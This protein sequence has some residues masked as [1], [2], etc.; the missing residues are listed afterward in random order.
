M[1]ADLLRMLPPLLLCLAVGALL[2]ALLLRAW[3]RRSRADQTLGDLPDAPAP[4]DDEIVLG[5]FDAVYVSTTRAT[6]RLSR[7]GSHTLGERSDA[8]LTLSRSD[9]GDAVV[10]HV[11]REGAESFALPQSL[12]RTAEGTSG[13]A[14]K[15]VGGEGILA[16]AWD[17]RGTDVV[18]GFRL[19]RRAE[20]AELLAALRSSLTPATTPGDRS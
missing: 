13:V 16:V 1:D 3:R 6:D 11:D 15:S 14:G 2:I 10:L 9:G 5:P 4:A 8:R 20:H 12:L 18:T 7:V 17:Y 19:R